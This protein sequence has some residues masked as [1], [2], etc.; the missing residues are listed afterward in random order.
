MANV[1]GQSQIVG[2]Q[3]RQQPGVNNDPSNATS[4][5]SHSHDNFNENLDV[6]TIE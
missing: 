6:E 4:S 5:T 3:N 2:K 1:I